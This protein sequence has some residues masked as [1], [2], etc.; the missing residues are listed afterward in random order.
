VV[1]DNVGS[2]ALFALGERGQNRILPR[3]PESK[4]ELQVI[5]AFDLADP[6]VARLTGAFLA[7]FVG[8][9]AIEIEV[10]VYT[11]SM[12]THRDGFI[13]GLLCRVVFQ[14]LKCQRNDWW[15]YCLGVAKPYF[16]NR[17]LIGKD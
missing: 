15:F 13:G 1:L 14:E 12:A 11:T 8:V 16:C 3:A 7:L 5:L 9:W 17:S 6:A 2:R 4:P 10:A